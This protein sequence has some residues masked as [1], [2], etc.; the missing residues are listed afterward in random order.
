M[1]RD[2]FAEGAAAHEL[3][4]SVDDLGRRVDDSLRDGFQP[5]H[6]RADVIRTG[7]QIGPRLETEIAQQISKARITER[8]NRVG[9]VDP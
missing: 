5:R 7:L 8:S 3:R 1:S 6:L 4:A 2:S 9:R